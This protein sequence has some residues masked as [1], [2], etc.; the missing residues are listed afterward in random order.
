[1]IIITP[2]LQQAI[3]KSPIWIQATDSMNS[4]VEQANREG[5]KLT[6]EEREGLGKL[7]ILATLALDKEVFGIYS[8]ELFHSMR[9]DMGLE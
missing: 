6:A 3:E 8:S 4:A 9:K 2:E 5:R 1:M 7:R